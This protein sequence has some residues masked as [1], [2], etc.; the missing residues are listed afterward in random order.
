MEFEDVETLLA[1]YSTQTV[2]IDMGKGFWEYL[3]V[4]ILEDGRKI[5]EYRRNYSA[6]YDTFCPFFLNGKLYALYSSYYTATRI[7]TLPDCEDIGGE[8]PDPNGFCPVGYYVPY[9]P[10]KGLNGNFGFVSGCVWGDDSSWKIRHID[11]SEAAN[12]NI[13]ISEKFGYLPMPRRLSLK[14]SID[15]RSYSSGSEYEEIEFC[16]QR[17]FSMKKGKFAGYYGDYD[18]LD[19]CSD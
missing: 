14:E 1:R 4:T 15:L 11:L 7:M 13:A 2:E 6:L 10:S 3:E 17:V 8:S 18:D 19:E 5:G 12:G 16:V 9:N